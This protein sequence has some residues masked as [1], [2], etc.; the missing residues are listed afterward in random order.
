VGMAPK[1]ECV[2]EMFVRLRWRGANL[3]V[4][5]SQ[6]K[7]LAADPKTKEAVADWHYWVGRGYEF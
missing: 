5:L 6:L 3:V 2:S 7:P 4:P 1:E